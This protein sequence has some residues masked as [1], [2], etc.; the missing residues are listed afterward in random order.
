MNINKKTNRQ[1]TVRLSQEQHQKLK[2]IS[3][4]KGFGTVSQYVRD[5]CLN[6]NN[7]ELHQKIDQILEKVQYG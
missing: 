2:E 1:V 7:T 3:R 4:A 6:T 5:Q